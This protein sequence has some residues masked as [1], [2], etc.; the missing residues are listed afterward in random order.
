LAG[1]EFVIQFGGLSL[2]THNYE[3]EISD[4]FFSFFESPEINNGKFK[5]DLELQKQ[6]TMLV[7]KFF[8]NGSTNVM[9]DRCSDEFDMKVEGGQHLIVKL[10]DEDFGDNDEIVS[11][12]LN[13]SEFDVS[14]YIY[15]FIVLSL[16]QRR[17][18]PDIKKGRTG[19]N[20]E[21]LK[22]LEQI[23]VKE[24]EKKKADPRWD[25]LKELKF[26]N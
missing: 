8:I 26:K 17:I 6:S 10:G 18:H 4:K 15:E 5:V 1:R 22:K 23:A 7:L 21:V 24:S 20:E 9:C 12:P 16:P 14:R 11:V 2:G 13:E 3:F 19:C 25:K